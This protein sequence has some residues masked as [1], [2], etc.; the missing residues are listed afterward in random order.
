MRLLER[1][2]AHHVNGHSKVHER[3]GHYRYGDGRITQRFREQP[4]AAG[5][6]ETAADCPLRHGSASLAAMPSNSPMV[7]VFSRTMPPAFRN[8]EA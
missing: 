1:I 3:S 8:L 4:S 6:N 7:F 5:P 2:P